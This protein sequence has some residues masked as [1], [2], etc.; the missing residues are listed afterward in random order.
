MQPLTRIEL[1]FIPHRINLWLCFG[2]ADQDHILDPIRRALYFAP[3]SVFGLVHWQTNTFGTTTQQLY[4]LRATSPHQRAVLFERASPGVECLLRVAG[5]HKVNHV[6]ALIDVIEDQDIDPAQVS[7]NYWR[8]IHNR[9][10]TCLEPHRYTRAAHVAYL[11]RLALG[12]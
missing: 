12:R 4:V 6:L 8:L 7:P 11:A 2:H 3:Q 10:A 5:E 1:N 9:L